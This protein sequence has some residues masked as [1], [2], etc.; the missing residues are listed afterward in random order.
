MLIEQDKTF[1][2][3]MSSL[4][5]LA[6]GFLASPTVVSVYHIL[7]VIPMF[8]VIK[9]ADSFHIPKR[10]WFLLLSQ[11]GESFVIL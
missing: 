4:M 6:I 8:I 1:K 9:R 2:W 5:F 3:I 7:I 11:F 10:G